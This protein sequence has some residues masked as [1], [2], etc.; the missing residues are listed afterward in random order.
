MLGARG[1]D[2]GRVAV[3]TGGGRTKGEGVRDGVGGTLPGENDEDL[4]GQDRPV[5]Q[6]IVRLNDVFPDGISARVTYGVLNLAHRRSHEF[7]EPLV[8]GERC[9]AVVKLNDVA[10]SFPA[11]HR[12]RVAIATAY[13]PIVWPAPEPVTLGVHT[14]TSALE[15]PVRPPSAADAHL[16]PFAAP[17]EGPG[18]FAKIVHP[19]T[20]HRVIERD[21]QTGD[22]I[23]RIF[24]DGGEFDGAA[25][26]YFE[27]ID[28]QAGFAFFQ[29]YRIGEYDPL[30]ARAEITAHATLRRK[31]WTPEL[32]S[33]VELRATK[34]AFIVTARL[35]ASEGDREI[36]TRAWD[37]TIPR[38]L[39]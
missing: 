34:A 15:L 6:V 35:T 38:D 12:I 8:P 26:V 11:G 32:R 10:H 27:E 16:R 25:L 28:L 33:V 4:E 29:R 13:W 37:E 22:L 18:E 30:S 19:P 2:G 31:R 3:G 24:D 39:I 5:A 17:E 1:A 21:V 23:Y 7:P 14:G 9:E 36:F 20:R